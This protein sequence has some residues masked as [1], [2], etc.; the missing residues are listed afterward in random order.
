MVKRVPQE[1]DWRGLNELRIDVERCLAQSCRD[2]GELEDLVQETLLRAASFRGALL[3]TRCLRSWVLRIAWNVLHDHVRREMRQRGVEMSDES[4]MELKCVEVESDLEA[5]WDDVHIAG[6]TYAGEDVL[7]VLQALV[8]DLPR[9]EHR[10]F[11]VYYHEG[12][13]CSST[14][15]RL[16]V[17]TQT[18]K[19]RLYRLRRKLRR[20]LRKQVA[21][22]LSPCHPQL[23]V[24]A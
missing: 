4:L 1:S 5:G 24:V 12:L 6:L 15:K 2:R 9:E 8:S 14:A 21:L 10:L 3:D 20:R 17:T 16:D 22:V 11:N 19:M 18:V 7:G 23:E 13:G